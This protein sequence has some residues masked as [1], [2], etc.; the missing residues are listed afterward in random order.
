MWLKMDMR[1]LLGG[2]ENGLKIGLW[3]KQNN[4]IMFIKIIKL[5]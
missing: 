2:D 4:F 5:N 1:D 3:Y